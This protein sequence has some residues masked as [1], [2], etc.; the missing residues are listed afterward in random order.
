MLLLWW[1]RPVCHLL[2]G[3]PTV[4]RWLM[5]CREFQD[6]CLQAASIKVLRIKWLA[7]S[8]VFSFSV[9]SL[10]EGVCV[11]KRIVLSFFSRLFDPL[12]F[13]APF[14]MFAKC[15][16]QEL[17]S[18]GLQWDDELPEEYKIQFLQWVDGLEILQ[19]WT[20][21]RSYTGV[22][23]TGVKNLQLHGFGD[24]SP[25]GYGACIF[26][27]AE[28]VDGSVATS[29]VIAKAK[30]APLKK[31]T[32]PRWELLGCLL[33]SRLL[34]FA[35]DAL[36]LPQDCVHCCW[37]DSMIALS[38]IRSHPSRWKTFMANRVA[39]IQSLTSSDNW[40]HYPGSENPADLLTRGLTAE[41]LV[42]SNVWLHGPKFLL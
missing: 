9:A 36:Q 11:T 20:I 4:Q 23:W 40:F 22:G 37:T 12:G 3:Y 24:A 19:R 38:W 39:E 16:F 27:R 2:S 10:P 1:N 34:V 31:L 15:L 30:I 41:E 26:L 14:A 33:C 29:L 6:K 32:L 18:F 42:N 21:P 7:A 35:R 5:C 28:M 13:T 8:D 17:W 25:K